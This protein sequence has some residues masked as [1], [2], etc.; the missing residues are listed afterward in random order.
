LL[1]GEVAPDGIVDLAAQGVQRFRLGEKS[2]QPSARIRSQ[3][4]TRCA[5]GPSLA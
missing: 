2:C 5:V 3:P 4:D 1:I